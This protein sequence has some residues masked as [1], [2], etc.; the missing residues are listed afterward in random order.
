MKWVLC[1]LLALPLLASG[2]QLSTAYMSLER[3]DSSVLEGQLQWRLYDL[4]RSLR[5]DSNRDGK[6]TWGEIKAREAAI[7]QFLG[8]RLSVAQGGVTCTLNSASLRKL[9]RHYAEPY[10]LLPLQVQCPISGDL[11]IRYMAFFNQDAD[12]KLLLS[13]EDGDSAISRVISAQQQEV[14]IAS[15]DGFWQ[16]F[17]DYVYQGVVH[18][19]IGWDH[20]LFLLCLLLV[21]VLSRR[22]HQWQARVA[23]REIILYTLTIVTAFTLA[24]SIT[25][26]ATALGWIDL[27]SRWVEI[28]IAATVIFAAVNNIVVLFWRIGW[29]T[30]GFGLLHGMGF[31][32]VLG[33]LGL[34]QQ[35]KLTAVVGFNL[36]VELGQLVIIALLLPVLML[37]RNGQWYRRWA[38]PAGSVLIALLGTR[39]LLER[40]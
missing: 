7:G 26:T 4:E 12:H 10:L 23:K 22:D 16:G 31:A 21:A 28:G 3:T 32:G 1:F 38:M 34:P 17:S 36:G 5:L 39:W 18:I 8:E 11:T 35:G 25:L 24:H 14:T 2:H 37:C 30:F 19:L 20:I 27:P 33:E 9:D 13:V 15:S 6:L 40:L 29:I